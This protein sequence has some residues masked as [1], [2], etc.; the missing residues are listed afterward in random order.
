MKNKYS[1]L[2]LMAFLLVSIGSKEHTINVDVKKA[3]RY[4][5]PAEKLPDMKAWS[6][7]VDWFAQA[8]KKADSILAAYENNA[9]RLLVSE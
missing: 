5:P 9:A 1:I 8:E 4:E 6:E 3:E 7:N 2:I